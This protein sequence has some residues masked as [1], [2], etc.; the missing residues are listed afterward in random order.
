MTITKNG[1]IKNKEIYRIKLIWVN[2]QNNSN[3]SNNN[4]SLF[5]LIAFKLLKD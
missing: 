5:A 4:K 3:N 2:N 1:L